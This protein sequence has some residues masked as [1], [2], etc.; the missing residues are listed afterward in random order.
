MSISMD[1]SVENPDDIDMKII[2]TMSLGQWK[3][4]KEQLT[5]EWPSSEM[6]AKIRDMIYQADKHFYPIEAK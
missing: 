3:R 6:S 4:L 1:M 2:I 5:L